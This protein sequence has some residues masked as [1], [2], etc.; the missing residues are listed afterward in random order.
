MFASVLGCENADTPFEDVA[1]LR[2]RGIGLPTK[3]K[4]PRP[5]S[6]HRIGHQPH[7]SHADSK[8]V[9]GLGERVRQLDI[10]IRQGSDSP[11]PSG[12][13]TAQYILLAPIAHSRADT[14]R[15]NFIFARTPLTRAPFRTDTLRKPLLSAKTPCAKMLIVQTPLT[16]THLRADTFTKSAF[17]AD[18]FDKEAKSRGILAAE[19]FF[20]KIQPA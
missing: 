3:G 11:L 8:G 9:G 7:P 12:L 19:T 20:K 13:F 16:R 17:R 2:C 18:T 6:P 4:P 15:K 10:E 1:E 5:F 14:L